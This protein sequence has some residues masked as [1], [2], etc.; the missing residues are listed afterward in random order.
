MREDYFHIK[1]VYVQAVEKAASTLVIETE[2]PLPHAGR[3]EPE[4]DT[5]LTEIGDLKAR[6]PLLFNNVDN[7]EIRHRNTAIPFS[8]R[9][10]EARLRLLPV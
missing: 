6:N 7:I 1:N 2:L 10:A 9:R 5:L 4:L 8:P 3:S